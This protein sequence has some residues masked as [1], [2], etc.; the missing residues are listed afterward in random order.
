MLQLAHNGAEVQHNSG[1][2]E[3]ENA[4]VDEDVEAI[5]NNPSSGDSSKKWVDLEK[6]EARLSGDLEN[7]WGFMLRKRKIWLKL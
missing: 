4:T 7:N 6:E 3:V 2:L 1:L 5:G